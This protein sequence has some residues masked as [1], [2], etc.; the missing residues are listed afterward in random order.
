MF[1]NKLDKYYAT[2]HSMGL[3]YTKYDGEGSDYPNNTIPGANVVLGTSNAVPPMKGGIQPGD[4][5][6][7]KWMVT[8][9]DGPLESGYPAQVRVFARKIK[10][11]SGTDAQQAHSYHSYI[12]MQ[13]DEDAGLI[14]P[15]I[16]YGQGMMNSTMS[17][18]RE[19][20]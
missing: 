9:S 18:Y 7:Y 8:P 14:G 4:C 15:T 1:V 3:A 12:A 5:T 11:G 10:R 13:S 20:P 19:F 17:N 6:V 2:M 16:I